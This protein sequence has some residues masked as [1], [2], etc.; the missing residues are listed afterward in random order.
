MPK[1]V[2]KCLINSVKKNNIFV[3]DGQN[4]YLISIMCGY[5][6]LKICKSVLL[7]GMDFKSAIEQFSDNPSMKNRDIADNLFI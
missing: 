2:E 7:D 3:S 6:C 4:Q 1:Q 5:Y